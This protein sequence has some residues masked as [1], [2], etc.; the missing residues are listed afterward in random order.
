MFRDRLILAWRTLFFYG[1]G[2]FQEHLCWICQQIKFLFCLFVLGQ[3]VSNLVLYAQSTS[4][5]VSGRFD[6][7][8]FGE[9]HG[10][11]VL[12]SVVCPWFMCFLWGLERIIRSKVPRDFSCSF[13]LPNF[14][15]GGEA[16]LTHF[17]ILGEWGGGGGGLDTVP[18]FGEG[19]LD[20]VP[21]FG[22][23]GLDTVPD[24]G[25]GGLDTIP[26]LGEGGLDTVPDLGEGGLD[27]V[28]DFGEGGLDTVPDFG[29]G[30]LDTVPDL[31]EGDGGIFTHFQIVGVGGS[32][33]TSRFWGSGEGS[34]LD[35]CR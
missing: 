7:Q 4:A 32:L 24:F 34:P 16:I 33:H 22:E 25:E 35:D 29:E 17:Q 11:V 1:A 12:N 8:K 19:G 2:L 23:K 20:T 3:P 26:D 13:T 9:K 15:E 14:R 6:N 21:D 30:G 31:G 18:D 10:K 27:T 28:P 5:V